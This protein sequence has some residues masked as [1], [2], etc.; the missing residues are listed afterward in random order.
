MT[1]DSR[2]FSEAAVRLTAEARKAAHAAIDAAFA[3]G[4]PVHEAGTGSDAGSTYR[5]WPDGRRELIEPSAD[6]AQHSN[7]ARTA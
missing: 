1:D 7:P 4:R 2:G 5:V 6:Q 3:A